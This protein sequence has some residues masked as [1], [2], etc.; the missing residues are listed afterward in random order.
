L[1]RAGLTNARLENTDE[2]TNS[3]RMRKIILIFKYMFVL[4][5]K[6]SPEM[7]CK[8]YEEN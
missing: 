7:N 2:A 1:I 6:I 5:D 8:N 3:A 4:S